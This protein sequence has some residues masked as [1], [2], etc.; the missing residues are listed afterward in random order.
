MA[1][2]G[3]SKSA[4]RMEPLKSLMW[5]RGNSREDSSGEHTD[6]EV[7]VPDAGVGGSARPSRVESR[8]YIAA[9]SERERERERGTSKALVQVVASATTASRRDVSAGC[10]VG[11]VVS[12]GRD[13]A[14]W[15]STVER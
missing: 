4:V 14:A 3:K 12:P 11:S 8:N 1:S 15:S 2:S 5:G 9:S 10:S 6:E 13:G 7:K